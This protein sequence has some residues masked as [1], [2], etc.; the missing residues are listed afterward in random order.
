MGFGGHIMAPVTDGTDI[1][2]LRAGSPSTAAVAFGYAQRRSWVFFAWWYPSIIA[3][4]GALH[5]L[6]ALLLGQDPEL[7]TSALIIGLALAGVGWVCTIKPRFTRKAPK[8]ASD[9][10]RVEQGLRISPTIS[11]TIL[12]GGAVLVLALVVFIP[13]FATAGEIPLLGMLIAWP[14]GASAGI[15]YVHWL[16]KNSPRLYAQWL[17]RR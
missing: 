4:G 1:G 12:A 11:W 17:G 16:M 15:A 2:Q 5:A 13:Q 3:L 6:L 9:I 8:P 14:A 7:G 10:P